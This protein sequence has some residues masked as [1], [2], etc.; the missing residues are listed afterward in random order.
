MLYKNSVFLVMNN[1]K[2][3][4]ENPEGIVRP[5]RWKMNEHEFSRLNIINW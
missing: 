4:P 3:N 2:V 5:G 1:F